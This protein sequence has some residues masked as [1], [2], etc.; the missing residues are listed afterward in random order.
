MAELLLTFCAEAGAFPR[1]LGYSVTEA[2][3]CL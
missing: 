1:E 3:I 2:S